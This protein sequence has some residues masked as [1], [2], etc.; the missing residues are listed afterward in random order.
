MVKAQLL[1]QMGCP[2]EYRGGLQIT[3]AITGLPREGECLVDESATEP[4]AA[5]LWQKVHFLQFANRFLCTLQWRY[6]ATTEDFPLRIRDDLIGSPRALVQRIEM[7]EPGI[8]HPI[9][10]G[11]GEAVFGGDIPDH[12]GNRC[13]ILGLQRPDG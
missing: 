8:R 1:V 7:I 5:Q 10:L 12:L 4:L 13:F 9:P 3:A 6:A 2:I 11:G